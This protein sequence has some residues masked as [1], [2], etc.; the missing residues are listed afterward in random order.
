[1]SSDEGMLSHPTQ[2]PDSVTGLI[3]EKALAMVKYPD[4]VMDNGGRNGEV[5]QDVRSEQTRFPHCAWL[6]QW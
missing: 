5:S 3:H 6:F 4:T 1:M 2:D